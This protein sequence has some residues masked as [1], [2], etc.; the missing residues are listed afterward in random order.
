ME[1]SVWKALFKNPMDNV[2]GDSFKNFDA[3]Q[4]AQFKM[5]AYGSA[6]SNFTG[7][8]QQTLFN[9]KPQLLT[10]I[11][12]STVTKSK[13]LD[14]Q[15]N[16]I[17][18][19]EIKFKT[20]E[21]TPVLAPYDGMVSKLN[22]QTNKSQG[23]VVNT[24]WVMIITPKETEKYPVLKLKNLTSPQFRPNVTFKKGDILAY[25][26]SD[27]SMENFYGFENDKMNNIGDY[28]SFVN[29]AD[30]NDYKENLQ[31]LAD[32][33]TE[34]ENEKL[35][36]FMYH[37]SR[38]SYYNQKHEGEGWAQK[39]VNWFHDPFHKKEEDINYNN[40]AAARNE[41]KNW[42]LKYY[43]TGEKEDIQPV[44]VT[45]NI[46]S[47]S[48]K[49]A[50]EQTQTLKEQ[51]LNKQAEKASIEPQPQEETT[52]QFTQVFSDNDDYNY[53]YSDIGLSQ[54]QYD[55]MTNNSINLSGV[56]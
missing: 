25:A 41:G 14:G 22:K 11:S 6:L 1:V 3:H 27:F 48:S 23:K 39:G 19:T 35:D 9:K 38:D 2:V 34:E 10:G 29:E 43:N 16:S 26:S 46:A 5:D 51:E 20:G 18:L 31:R 33:K 53:S 36:D 13:A 56:N 49:K 54:R 17:D 37:K 52:P 7:K 50:Q 30:Q 47:K 28:Q 15:G 40:Y 24:R 55:A 12:S 4:D 21:L 45:T 8:E 42:F 32:T 44:D